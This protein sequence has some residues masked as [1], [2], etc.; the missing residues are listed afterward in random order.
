MKNIFRDFKNSIVHSIVHPLFK[1]VYSPA[2][3]NINRFQSLGMKLA[4]NKNSK[5][6]DCN[7]QRTYWKKR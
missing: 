2:I 6:I 3:R 1:S 4:C 5:I 7:L